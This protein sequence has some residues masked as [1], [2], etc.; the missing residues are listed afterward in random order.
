MLVICLK[1]HMLGLAFNAVNP[2]VLS[3]FHTLYHM[4]VCGTVT[5]L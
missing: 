1:P 2:T 4:I 3:P 5:I